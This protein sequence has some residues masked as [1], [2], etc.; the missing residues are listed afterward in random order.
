[1]TMATGQTARDLHSDADE[2]SDKKV[3]EHDQT[4]RAVRWLLK[5]SGVKSFMVHT[6]KPRL[7]GP[8]VG[9]WFVRD[10]TLHPP[11][12]I[13]HDGEGSLIASVV[14]GTRSGCFLV[15]VRGPEPGLHTVRRQH[16][17]QVVGHVLAALP[18]VEAG[19]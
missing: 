8:S 1:M 18:D 11:E 14:L 7:R 12:L 5:D 2:V 15:A 16:V 10:R 19:R 9:A 17:E 13:V 6:V 3:E 4:L